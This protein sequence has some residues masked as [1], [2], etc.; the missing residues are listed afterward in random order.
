LA[1]R[2]PAAQVLL[3]KVGKRDDD[4]RR[5]HGNDQHRP[6]AVRLGQAEDKKEHGIG[7]VTRAMELEL[8][9]LRGA[10]GEPLGHL[11]M[12]EDVEQA[13]RELKDDQAPKHVRGHG[14]ISRNMAI[15]RMMR[16]KRG[17]KICSVKLNLRSKSSAWVT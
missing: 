11:M 3:D 14:A 2:Q 5:Q 4:F 9:A 10:P 17:W 7:Q 6:D 15:W 8:A 12:I 1:R 13:E 16:P